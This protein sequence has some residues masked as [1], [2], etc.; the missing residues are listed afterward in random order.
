[1]MGILHSESY[2]LEVGGK[3]TTQQLADEMAQLL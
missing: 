2:R 3:L 1:M